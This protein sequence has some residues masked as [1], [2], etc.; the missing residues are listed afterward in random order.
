MPNS[1]SAPGCKLT[2][3]AAPE[4]EGLCSGTRS[5]APKFAN[6]HRSLSTSGHKLYAPTKRE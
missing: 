2:V 6:Q 1:G 3:P 4:V 5:A